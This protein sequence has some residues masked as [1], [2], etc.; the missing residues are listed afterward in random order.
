MPDAAQHVNV[1]VAVI[2][3]RGDRVLL[4]RRTGAHGEGTWAL[5]G[6]HLAFGETIA[7]CARREVFEET[8]LRIEG[9]RHVDF[10][11]DLFTDEKKHYVTLFVAAECHTGEPCLREPDKC[12]EWG[13]FARSTLP[14]PLFLP[15]R[16][17][18]ENRCPLFPTCPAEKP[19]SPSPLAP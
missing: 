18:I 17:L 5:P 19:G 7:A 12:T 14:E 16:N 8:G 6:G 1:G 11:N 10:T 2:V 15:L 9:I 13:W 3:T 4:G